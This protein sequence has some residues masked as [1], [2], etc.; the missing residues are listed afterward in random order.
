M[1]RNFSRKNCSFIGSIVLIFA[2]LREQGT[3]KEIERER[4]R[5]KR[6]ERGWKEIEGRKREYRVLGAGA[7]KASARKKGGNY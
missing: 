5:E 2:R 7:G 1:Q 6:R 4:K 3:E